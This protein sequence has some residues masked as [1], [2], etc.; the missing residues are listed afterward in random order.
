MESVAVAA[1]DAHVG[2]FIGEG[3]VESLDL[4]VGLRPVGP[5][6]GVDD[7]ELGAERG[8]GVAAV[9]DTVIGEDAFDAHTMV[10]EPCVRA[11]E[12]PG[13]TFSVFGGQDLA[14]RDAAVRVDRGVDMVV[15]T[16]GV[17]HA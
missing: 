3:A 8:P 15:A 9:A 10:G 5:G 11:T 14:I 16:A 7:I 1:V 13:A 2:P 17:A 12:K 6:P 4:P